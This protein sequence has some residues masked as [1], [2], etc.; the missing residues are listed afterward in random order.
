M[1]LGVFLA[2][3]ESWEDFRFKGQDRLLIN[4]NY[5]YYSKYF[6]KVFVFS[7]GQNNLNLLKNVDLLA[8]PLR[9]HRYLFT[10]FI[11]LLYS[12]QIKQCSVLRGM[13]LTSALPGLIAKFL[14]KKKFVVNYGYDYVKTAYIE[15]K[16][17]Q[18]VCY[19]IIERFLLRFV[20]IVIVTTEKLNHKVKTLTKKPVEIIPNSVNTQLFKPLVHQKKDIDLLFVGRL[21]K[22]KNLEF[23]LKT[24]SKLKNKA[25]SIVFV[26]DGSL[27][28]K[29]LEMAKKLKINLRITGFVPHNITINYYQRSKIFV[30]PSLIEGHPKVLL[31]A[32]SCSLAVVG[33]AREGIK[34]LIT[35]N[36]DGILVDNNTREYVKVMNNLIENAI[37]RNKIG[38][39][40]RQTILR[41]FDQKRLFLR[42]IQLL[43]NLNK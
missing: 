22:Q 10:F 16:P 5:T 15:S 28:P 17:I 34:E 27:K 11:P 6:N 2:I 4:N 41:K 30:L 23:L 20:D 19:K 26:G 37:L 3:G 7:Y 25:S 24:I 38:K 18:A 43:K 21:E 35:H 31:E 39:I 32:M 40:A 1:N 14:Y 33:S 12:S 29:L 8:N 13:Q 36:H 42:E 9:L